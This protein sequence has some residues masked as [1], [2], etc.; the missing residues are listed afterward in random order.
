M[1]DCPEPEMFV[2]DPPMTL[3]EAVEELVEAINCNVIKGRSC[4]DPNQVIPVIPLQYISCELDMLSS[5]LK[6]KE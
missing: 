2:D 3:R 4:Y 6:E 5:F 1:R